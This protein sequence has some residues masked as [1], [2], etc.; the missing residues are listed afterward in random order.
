M[1]TAR[2]DLVY[3]G[4]MRDTARKIDM[5]VRGKSRADFDASEDLRLVLA[6]LVQIVGEAASKVS[7]STR[8]AYTQIPWHAITGIRHRIVHDYMN[9]DEDVLWMVATRN[10]PELIGWLESSMPA[11]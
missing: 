6:H 5:R 11:D 9:I 4:H 8:I 3:L 7:S 10:I 2:D 1:S